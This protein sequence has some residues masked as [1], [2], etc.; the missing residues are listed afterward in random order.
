MKVKD[1]QET[2]TKGILFTTKKTMDKV[3]HQGRASKNQMK[4]HNKN[5][6]RHRRLETGKKPTI[7]ND[8]TI[9]KTQQ[10][11]KKIRFK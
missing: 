5:N 6:N 1:H 8:P 7:H 3:K 2:L 11:R 10:K 4:R 9:L